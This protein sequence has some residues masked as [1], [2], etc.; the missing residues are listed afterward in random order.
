MRK[1]GDNLF[2]ANTPAAMQAA[3]LPA[4]YPG[5][6]EQSN[7]N[8]VRSL[9]QMITV[10]RG[11]DMAQRALTTQDDLLRHASNELGKL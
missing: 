9:V 5:F 11:F 10:T 1:D 2:A 7:V 4:T 3:A 6:L 8:S